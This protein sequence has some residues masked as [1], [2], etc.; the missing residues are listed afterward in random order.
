MEHT[1]QS[2]IAILKINPVYQ[3]Y[4][5]ENSPK[6]IAFF[7]EIRK[8]FIVKDKKGRQE[9]PLID[10]EI[11][12][13]TESPVSPVMDRKMP[14]I[15]SLLMPGLGHL[16]TKP[17]TKGW[18]LFGSGVITLGLSIYYIVDVNR[19]EEAYLQAT[20]KVKIEEK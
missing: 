17:S 5:M 2:F 15:Y 1:L 14:Q 18:A 16:A 7:E 20:S 9:K 8:N 11:K 12:V 10:D 13:K 19:K 3:L 4:R 6:I